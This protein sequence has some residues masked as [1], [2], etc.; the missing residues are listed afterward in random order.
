MTS[1]DGP[2]R[3]GPISERV[4]NPEALMRDIRRMEN[5]KLLFLTLDRVLQHMRP[6]PALRE[7]PAYWACSTPCCWS[8]YSESP[9]IENKLGR[10]PYIWLYYCLQ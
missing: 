3:A 5:V 9:K 10:D 4:V 6:E 7:R 2:S 8:L 1:A